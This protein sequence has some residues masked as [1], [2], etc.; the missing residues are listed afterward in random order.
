MQKVMIQLPEIKLI[1]ISVRTNNL[2]ELNSTTAKISPTIQKYFHHDLFNKTMH[3]KKPGTTYCVYTNYESDFKGDY[4]FFI[5]EEVTAF[6]SVTLPFERLVIPQQNYAKFTNGPN[7][8]PDVC[9]Q[10]WQQIWTMPVASLGGE[11]SYIADFEVYD[12]RSHDPQNVTLDIYI[13]I[14]V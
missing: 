5:G 9:I 2:T 1:G 3:R 13:G 7:K 4:T 10:A 8:L 14:K 11:R 12:E 6:E